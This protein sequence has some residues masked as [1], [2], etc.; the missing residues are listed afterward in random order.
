MAGAWWS[1]R[2]GRPWVQWCCTDQ[3]GSLLIM[4]SQQIQAE[5]L[6]R[7]NKK[8]I[9]IEAQL[10]Q[11][12]QSL[13]SLLQGLRHLLRQGVIKTLPHGTEHRPGALHPRSKRLPRQPTHPMAVTHQS[14][15]QGQHRLDMAEHWNR[16]QQ[17]ISH[18]DRG[19][20]RGLL[21]LT[22]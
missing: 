2:T 21:K 12:A 16:Q 6:R 19:D 5:P 18:G 14:T 8:D 20:Q 11:T 17:Q 15:G 3:V 13:S 4:E 22:S 9:K 7:L 1:E 10:G